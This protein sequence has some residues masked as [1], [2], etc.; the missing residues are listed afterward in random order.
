MRKPRSYAEIIND[1]DG[2]T[3]NVFQV[4]R[5]PLLGAELERQLRLTPFARTEFTA[6]Y[7]PSSDQLE[8]AR[9]TIIRS[10][11]GFGA[12]GTT[13]AHTGF[14]SNSN[15]SGTTPAHDW[16]N[17]PDQVK[18]FT[19]RLAGVVIESRDARQIMATHDS[20][21]TLHYVDPPYLPITRGLKNP[22][23]VKNQYRHEMAP[24][25]HAALLDFLNSLQGMVV[26]S[27]Y[28]SS[29]YDG[30]LS[31]WRRIARSAYADGARKRIEVLWL[32]PAAAERIE[33]VRPTPILQVARSSS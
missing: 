32:N 2:E 3:V 16:R 13:G 23:C 21:A 20:P 24:D 26:L 4:L 8:Q 12:V 14:R 7:E 27:G 33:Y 31:H 22:H 11:M 6:G 29:L 17:Y 9:R 25:E 30:R 19:D 1:L 18:A 28:P 10:F 15:R 5:D